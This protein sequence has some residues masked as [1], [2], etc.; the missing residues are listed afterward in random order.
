MPSYQPSAASGWMS[1]GAMVTDSPSRSPS[2]CSASSQSVVGSASPS[3]RTVGGSRM[4]T[5][6]RRSHRRLGQS[7][8]HRRSRCRGRRTMR[9]AR[10]DRSPHRPACPLP[11]RA[12]RP[13]SPRPA[14]NLSR[15][16]PWCPDRRS[17]PGQTR[18]R[19]RRSR[20]RPCSPDRS[21]RTRSPRRW[22]RCRCPSDRS[23]RGLDLVPAVAF[24]GRDPVAVAIFEAP[25]AAARN[26]ER[27]RKQNASRVEHRCISPRACHSVAPDG[28]R[29]QVTLLTT[30]KAALHPA[31]SSKP[32]LGLPR[33]IHVDKLS[34]TYGAV[35]AIS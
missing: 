17:H 19:P 12:G 24:S 13:S 1:A 15:R 7:R 30:L 11:E 10:P 18:R 21:R 23:P 8:P 28:C 16:R 26:Q 4:Q 34:K 9:P 31:V 20:R 27:D 6:R 2:A 32:T 25:L 29:Q 3:A 35:Q 14:G 33:M 5:E 22:A